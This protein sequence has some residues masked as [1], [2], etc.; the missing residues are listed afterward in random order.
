M[1]T[2]LTLQMCH[3]S[4]V[5][6]HRVSTVACHTVVEHWSPRP[7]SAEAAEGSHS[8]C[9]AVCMTVSPGWNVLLYTVVPLQV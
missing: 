4:D 6:P 5:I 3:L 2:L 1:P 8:V 7:L 9:A